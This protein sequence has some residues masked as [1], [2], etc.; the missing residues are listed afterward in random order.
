MSVVPSSQEQMVVSLYN[1]LYLRHAAVAQFESASVEDFP[2]FV[3]SREAV[4]DKA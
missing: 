4:I 2:E 3:A 1:L